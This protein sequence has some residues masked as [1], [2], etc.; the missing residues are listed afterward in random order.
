MERIWFNHWF[1]TAYHFI[2]MLKEDGYYVIA[3]NQR[4]TC[5][6][7]TVADEF[8]LEEE[9][10][11]E[12]YL[13]WALQF[14]QEHNIDVFFV[15]KHMDVVVKNI[16]K[17]EILGTKVICEKEEEMYDLLQDKMA[18][19]DYFKPL[20]ICNIPEMRVVTNVHDFAK[21]YQDLKQKY[22][23][24]CIKYNKDEGGQSYKLIDDKF[25]SIERITDECKPTYSYGFVY[26]C[27]KS[28]DTFPELIVMPYLDGRE[29]SVDCLEINN[30][31][32]AIPRYKL[33]NRVTKLSLD[34]NIIDIANEMHKHVRLT[35]PYNIQFRYDKGDLYLLEINTRLA[36]GAWK[37]K[38]LGCEFPN[39]AVKKELGKECKCPKFEK[40]EI[41]LSN[42]ENCVDL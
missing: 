19:M 35:T 3:T 33:T 9:M 23:K 26:D 25:P 30:K 31:L 15:K 20:N 34:K 22:E 13:K 1:S 32:I 27:L 40:Q 16:V 38:Y 8:Y 5:V 24:I 39:L 36:G 42:I 10:D 17:F 41:N 12:D 4:D 7:K 21:T 29:V 6:Y 28:V 2:N 18:T 11:D 37:S 14:V